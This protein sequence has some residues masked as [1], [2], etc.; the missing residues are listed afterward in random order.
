MEKVS[1]EIKEILKE[2]FGRDSLIALATL[3]GEWPSVRTVNAVYEEGAFYVITYALSGK[4]GQIEKCPRVAVSGEW[5]TA[6]GMGENLGHVLQPRHH[7]IME[8]LRSAFAS[9]YGNGHVNEQDP[10]TCLLR[11]RL[12]EGIL[13][14]H[15]RRYEIDFSA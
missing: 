7:Q 1:P 3:D 6:R 12:T 10:H 9:W 13:F 5:F 2:R 8:K 11:I 15:G 14:S 4:M